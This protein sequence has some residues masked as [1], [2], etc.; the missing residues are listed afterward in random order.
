[1]KA[2]VCEKYGP[3]DVLQLKEVEKPM[4]KDNE[5]LIKVMTTA[6]SSGDARIRGFN[7]PPLPWIPFRL[8]MGLRGPR[9]KILGID[10]AGEI[11][12]VGKDVKSFRK[13]EQV[14]G[15]T[16][17]AFGAY[18][19]FVCMPAEG[20]LTTM[21]N[22]ITH[23]EAAA[24]FFGGNTALHFLRKGNIQSGQKVL[25]YG[26]SGSV[27]TSA[28]QL[29]KHFG[30]EVIGICS[31]V[32]IELVK[33]LGA[34]RVID[35]SRDDFTKSGD[36][37]DIIFDTVG[38]S[39]H[40]NCVRS[41]I[42][43]GYFLKAVNM[44]MLPILQSIWTSITSSKKVIGGV[45][46]ENT[47]ALIYLKELVESGKLKPVIDKVYPLEQTADAHRYVDLGHK[48]GNVVIEV[49]PVE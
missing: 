14:F 23:R 1:M 22:N 29:A 9:K 45:A 7:V 44:E 20:V 11:V 2:I 32:N 3:P 6:V 5:V 46:A 41:L 12:K 36:K 33:E 42:N 13:G 18:A 16:G 35:Y 15:S 47:E 38:K 31:T 10:F 8:F 27:G 24:I 26:A 40:S 21:P 43:K 48:K 19:E 4:P 34:D 49:Q 28:V 39:S 17:S 25:V 30:A 37:Y